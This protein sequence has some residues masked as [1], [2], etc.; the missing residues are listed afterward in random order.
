MLAGNKCDLEELRVIKRE[1]AIKFAEK[2]KIAFVETSAFNGANI[3]FAFR[4]L[5]EGFSKNIYIF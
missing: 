5:V 1:E 4:K 3:D 2:T